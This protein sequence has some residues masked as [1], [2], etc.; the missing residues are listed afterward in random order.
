MTTKTAI[1]QAIRHKGLDCSVYQPAEVRECPVTRCGLWSFRFGAD[2]DP[3]RTRGFAKSPVYTGYSEACAQDGTP[4]PAEPSA[5]EISPLHVSFG[6]SGPIVIST[7]V[8]TDPA[9][10]LPATKAR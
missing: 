7:A 2:P 3:S 10:S 9:A 8:R 4:A 1:L 6:E 5:S